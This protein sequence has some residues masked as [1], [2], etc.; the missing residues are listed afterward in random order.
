M[1]EINATNLCKDCASGP[2]TEKN[3]KWKALHDVLL[4]YGEKYDRA[5][6]QVKRA[7]DAL[8]RAEMNMIRIRSAY[9]EAE[10]RLKTAVKNHRIAK[11]TRA[12]AYEDYDRTLAAM[13]A[14]Y[15]E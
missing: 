4:R 8:A 5:T 11:E 10:S 13:D 15:E 12:R 6:E 3:A 14:I 2:S 9:N 1:V 7:E